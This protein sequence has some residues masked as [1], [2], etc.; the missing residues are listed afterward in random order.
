MTP[1]RDH[2]NDP[3]GRWRVGGGIDV[4]VKIEME[5]ARKSIR[6]LKDELLK[7]D[8]GQESNNN[9]VKIFRR[10]QIIVLC[11]Q[12]SFVLYS[13]KNNGQRRLL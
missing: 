4:P 5:A 6:E 12:P 9:L 1:K 11:Q 13:C 2:V 7:L 8:I 10:D 3:K